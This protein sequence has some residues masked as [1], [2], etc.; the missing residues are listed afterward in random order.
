MLSLS[1]SVLCADTMNGRCKIMLMRYLTKLDAG[2][3]TAPED[4]DI[5]PRFVALCFLSLLI[6]DLL[7]KMSICAAT[8]RWRRC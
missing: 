3:P 5:D 1:V 4:P 2:D 7:F 8:L 6:V